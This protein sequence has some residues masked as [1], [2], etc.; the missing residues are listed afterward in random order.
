MKKE[1]DNIEKQKSLVMKIVSDV[2]NEGNFS[3]IIKHMKL[4]PEVIQMLHDLG[5]E[6]T[7][8][9]WTGYDGIPKDDYEI[10]W[11]IK[12]DKGGKNG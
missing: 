8:T 9:H 5:Y 11:E 6:I 10:N 12:D 4:Y 1:A 3:C 7:Q 2:I